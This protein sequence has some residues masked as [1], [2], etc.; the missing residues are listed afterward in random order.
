MI[1]VVICH[2]TSLVHL[3]PIQ[4]MY[5]AKDVAEVVFDHVYKHHGMPKHIVS[6]C[7]TLFTST[8]RLNE[9]TG[10]EL[11]MLSSYHPQSDGTTERANQTVTQMLC[12]CGRQD[13]KD[14]ASKLPTIEFAINSASSSTTG[15][16]PF[17]MNYGRLPRSMIWSQ[18]TG[19]PGV[20]KFMQNMKD[21][22]LT[23]HDA[24]LS[25]RV[26]QTRIVNSRRKEAPFSIG[27]LVYLSTKNLSPPK[28][29][30]RKL[31]PKFIGLFKIIE[32]Y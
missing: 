18:D 28:G 21:T 20:K 32:D 1:M 7:D 9:L 8:W 16:P 12:Q 4:Q 5:R 19:Y 31:S 10:T 17:V 15:Y 26:K 23:A 11:R 29:R 22:L 24:I 14:W 6:D 27:D 25:A 3:V 2:L 13:Q 30:A